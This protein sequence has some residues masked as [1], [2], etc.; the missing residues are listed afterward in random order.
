M[1]VT[2]VVSAAVPAPQQLER[3][4]YGKKMIS[5]ICTSDSHMHLLHI[6]VEIMD[7]FTIF[8]GNS[9]IIRSSSIGTQNNTIFKYYANN[10]GTGFRGFR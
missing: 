9:R 2:C 3:T 7:F 5:K 8:I 1:D 6:L 10:S 4:S